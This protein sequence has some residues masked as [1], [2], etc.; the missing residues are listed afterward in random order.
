MQTSC[1][2]EIKG[3]EEEGTY[4]IR[5]PS[6][7][8]PEALQ[9]PRIEEVDQ[10]YVVNAL[11]DAARKMRTFATMW[12]EKGASD[13]DNGNCRAR[14]YSLTKV[15]LR[16][17]KRQYGDSFYCYVVYVVKSDI[18]CECEPPKNDSEKGKTDRKKP[19]KKDA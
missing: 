11:L 5:S 13:C 14:K 2:I 9:C 7:K 19:R 17:E 4:R 3:H 16:M 15:D 18:S 1:H 8:D 10:R 12:C 6:S